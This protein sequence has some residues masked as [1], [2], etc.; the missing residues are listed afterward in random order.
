MSATCTSIAGK[1]TTRATSL[2]LAFSGSGRAGG[3]ATAKLVHKVYIRTI[4]NLTTFENCKR[5]RF[6]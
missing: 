2:A 4:N 3:V 6:N 5:Y 1:V